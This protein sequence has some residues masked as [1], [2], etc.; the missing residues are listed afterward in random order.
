LDKHHKL[1][2]HKKF[3]SVKNKRE[4]IE[5]ENNVKKSVSKE[6]F[7]SSVLQALFIVKHPWS[8]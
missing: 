3:E 7:V 6:K 8:D 4:K 2:I 5:E 1:K